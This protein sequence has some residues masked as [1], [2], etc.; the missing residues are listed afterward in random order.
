MIALF[1]TN[2][3]VK[4]CKNINVELGYF[5]SF[6]LIA[7]LRTISEKYS[8]PVGMHPVCNFHH[9]HS[10][11]PQRIL[12]TT[13]PC[14]RCKWVKHEPGI[15]HDTFT[16]LSPNYCNFFGLKH[17]IFVPEV[18]FCCR[19][20]YSNFDG[21]HSAKGQ[22][23]ISIAQLAKVSILFLK[24]IALL[25]IINR[26]CVVLES[27][28]NLCLSTSVAHQWETCLKVIKL[29]CSLPPA[30]EE[31]QQQPRQQQPLQQ[32][33]QQQQQHESE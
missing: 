11:L 21:K 16:C 28:P 20:Q 14:Q 5:F 6:I 32:Q 33:Q 18:L 17:F 1:P 13:F 2:S 22:L 24:V 4:S 27:S 12:I 19:L 8:V 10:K 7:M 29:S 26:F 9:D 25:R 3:F 15:K 30:P 31:K 23:A